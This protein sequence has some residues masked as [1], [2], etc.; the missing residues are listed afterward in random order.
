MS[1]LVMHRRVNLNDVSEKFLLDSIVGRLNRTSVTVSL[2]GISLVRLQRLEN[3][4]FRRRE[5]FFQF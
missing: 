3:Q 2:L 1:L 5:E 4:I